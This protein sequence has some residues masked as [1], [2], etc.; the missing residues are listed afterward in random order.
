MQLIF[1][2]D[3]KDLTQKQ[4]A[5]EWKLAIFVSV[6]LL[7]KYRP[8]SPSGSPETTPLSSTG[9]GMWCGYRLS[10][11]P[12]D[13]RCSV[14]CGRACW[15]RC[16]A[17]ACIAPPW[18]GSRA[19]RTSYYRDSTLPSPTCKYSRL[20]EKAF[21]DTFQLHLFLIV[22]IP[23]KMHTSWQDD[24]QYGSK[25]IITTFNAALAIEI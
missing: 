12:D 19:S 10:S 22:L 13:P 1:T 24:K 7:Y 21:H 6:I 18:S 17:P 5:L 11:S 25:A 14:C 23:S 20:F 16:G 8:R 4:Q 2:G 9:R 15:C 3:S